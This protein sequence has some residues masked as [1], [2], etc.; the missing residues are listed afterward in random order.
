MFS[1]LL[2]QE[3]WRVGWYTEGSA[4][5]DQDE[6]VGSVTVEYDV[7]W[8]WITFGERLGLEYNQD[9]RTIRVPVPEQR[10]ISVR[11]AE[12]ITRLD[13]EQVYS[14][15]SYNAQPDAAIEIVEDLPLNE[16][17][18]RWVVPLQTFLRFL[19]LG[20]VSV[21]KVNARPRGD[22]A[23]ISLHYNLFRPSASEDRSNLD[24]GTR[25]LLTPGHLS[26]RSLTLDSVL[27]DFL[28]LMDD[29]NHRT[30]LWL[31]NESKDRLHGKLVDTAL[32]NVFRSLERY[33]AAAI[34]G[35]R[36]QKQQLRDVLEC[37]TATAS[38]ITDTWPGFFDSIVDLRGRIAHGIPQQSSEMALRYLSAAR[39]LQWI[40]RHVY[41]NEIGLSDHQAAEI[42]ARCIAFE[43]ELRHLENWY[44]QLEHR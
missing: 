38:R 25:V 4:W 2:D 8:E 6:F 12:L 29:D 14:P 16:V 42:V 3:T 39:G 18:D 20:Y 32:L 34:G 35:R 30:A 1:A 19:T 28:D 27:R 22:N 36:T 24:L 9:E 23:E 5:L 11:G 10:P 17:R 43:Q 37:A 7:L 44:Q 13:W 31:L 40:M 26:T 41:L 21:D 15:Y 33:H